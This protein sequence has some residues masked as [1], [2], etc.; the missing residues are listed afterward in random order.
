MPLL[1]LALAHLYRSIGSH[2]EAL[3][4]FLHPSLLNAEASV[5][6]PAVVVG[7]AGSGAGG[8]G[9]GGGGGGS[10]GGSGDASGDDGGRSWQLRTSVL[11]SNRLGVFELIKE[12][13]MYA[14]LDVNYSINDSSS[15]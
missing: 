6:T 3:D 13:H 14:A 1:H 10:G 9:G 8:G 12:H 11:L 15:K 4:R 5:L 2:K 7:S